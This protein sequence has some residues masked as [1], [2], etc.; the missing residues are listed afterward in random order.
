MK[1]RI[2]LKKW[3]SNFSIF[4]IQ[5]TTKIK[6]LIVTSLLFILFF[7]LSVVLLTKNSTTYSTTELNIDEDA[8]RYMIH[9]DD[10]ERPNYEELDFYSA[11]QNLGYEL[12]FLLED[13]RDYY[14]S[15]GGTT[16]TLEELKKDRDFI[17]L[18]LDSA[19]KKDIENNE[20]I[21]VGQ[22]SYLMYTFDEAIHYLDQIIY[23]L[24]N[25]KEQIDIYLFNKAKDKIKGF[26]NTIY[27]ILESQKEKQEE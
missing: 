23:F 17:L 8:L 3:K 20:S 9:R 4:S 12:D 26:N 27:Y 22:S 11:L 5:F 14:N 2:D 6:M 21:I 13:L 10:F 18:T 16:K 7:S 25:D 19:V 24:Q 1:R 15:G